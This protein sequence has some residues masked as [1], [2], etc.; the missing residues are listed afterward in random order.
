MLWF[1][2]GFRRFLACSLTVLCAGLGIALLSGCTASSPQNQSV[3]TLSAEQSQKIFGGVELGADDELIP[4][5]VSIESESETG[6]KIECTGTLVHPRVVLTAAHCLEDS[7]QFLKSAKIRFLTRQFSNQ[8]TTPDGAEEEL[9]P[10][11][12]RRAR[13]TVRPQLWDEMLFNRPE[14]LAR[15]AFDV[16]LIILDKAAPKGTR[17]MTL[18]NVDPSF[19]SVPEF[20]AVG[21]GAAGGRITQ[22]EG[23]RMVFPSGAGTLR[24]ALLHR[25]PNPTSS[26]HF[27]VDQAVSGI[28]F[29]DSGGPALVKQNGRWIQI[30]VSSYVTSLETQAC[31]RMGYFL[32]LGYRAPQAAANEFSMSHWIRAEIENQTTR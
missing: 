1:C 32:N 15:L 13:R 23:R 4:F 17:I 10:E 6:Q 21:Y 12:L 28:C 11:N 16:G 7:D 8:F 27:E 25:N 9:Y 19:S 24:R 29:G 26:L 14:S 30:G 18:S 3:L 22:V 2:V 31:R 20:T 5:I